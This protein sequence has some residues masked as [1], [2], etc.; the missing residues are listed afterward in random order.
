VPVLCALGVACTPV[1]RT[2]S[3]T[4]P[5]PTASKMGDTARTVRVTFGDPFSP[6]VGAAAVQAFR[7]DIPETETGGEC[8]MRKLPSGSRATNTVAYFPTRESPKMS[9]SI[10]FDSAGHLV[11]YSEMR[12]V[13]GLRNLPPGTS[14]PARDSMLK[15]QRDAMRSTTISLNYA[16]DQAIARN[17]GGGKPDDA[18]FASVREIESLQVLG[19]VKDRLA[20]VRKLCGV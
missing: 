13:T 5:Q 20:R 17:F 2:V 10:T 7:P 3:G 9:V 11:Q 12:G 14:I 8:T 4:G 19:P 15:A 18:V 16:I 6:N 1:S